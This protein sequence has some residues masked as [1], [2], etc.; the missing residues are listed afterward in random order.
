MAPLLGPVEA[1]SLDEAERVSDARAV[2]LLNLGIVEL[3]SFRLDD[4]RRHLEQALTLARENRRA[5]VEIGALSHLAV[6]SGPRSLADARRRGLEAIAIAESNGWASDPV[7]A[8]AL[9]ILALVDVARGQFPRG[10]DVGRS[11]AGSGA[12]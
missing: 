8:P 6:L 7:A 3:W 10:S 1:A 4:A 5:Y 12:T 9:G 11:R 2:A